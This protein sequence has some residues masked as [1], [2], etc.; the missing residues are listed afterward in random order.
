MNTVYY[1]AAVVFK[2]LISDLVVSA[3]WPI[4]RSSGFSS[5]AWGVTGM[6]SIT[7]PLQQLAASGQVASHPARDRAHVLSPELDF[8]PLQSKGVLCAS[9]HWTDSYHHHQERANLPLC[10]A[11]IF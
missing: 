7:G 5:P 4:C 8:E 11:H 3:V 1:L 10:S 6:S 2:L 9:S